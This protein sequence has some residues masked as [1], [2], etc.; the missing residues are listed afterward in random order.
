MRLHT[1]PH[2]Y[3]YTYIQLNKEINTHTC[4]FLL[5]YSRKN[6]RKQKEWGTNVVDKCVYYIRI[7][8]N[9]C[10]L[11]NR[12]INMFIVDKCLN[13]DDNNNKKIMIIINT[14][15]TYI[16]IKKKIPFIISFKISWKNFFFKNEL[17]SLRT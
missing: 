12:F 2:T 4:D 6:F 16:Q 17:Q 10:H 11:V 15:F 13:N 5:I 9:Y 14:L 3:T 1:H 7:M 8:A